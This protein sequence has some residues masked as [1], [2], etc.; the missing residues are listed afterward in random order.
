T[1]SNAILSVYANRDKMSTKGLEVT[2]ARRMDEYWGLNAAYT[3]TFPRATSSDPQ[4]YILTFGRQTFFDPVTGKR[5]VQ[6][7]PRRLTPIDYDRTHQ[8]NLQFNF[9][10]P[11]L[12][13]QGSR[14][15]Q[16][17][18]DI[19]GFATFTFATG[20]PYTAL[21]QSGHPA[22]TNNNDRGPSYK[23]FDLRINKPLPVPGSRF[24][25]ALF[26]EIHNLFNWKNYNIDF[27]NPTT[28]SARV[29]AFT[30]EEAFND[31]PDFRGDRGEKV[32]RISVSD[33][34]DNLPGDDAANLVKIQDI[35]GDGFITKN[36]IVALKLANLLASLDDPRA[37]IRPVEVR[38]GVT[39][40]F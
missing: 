39:V 38:L 14:P 18:R 21:D 2:F 27:I 15:E 33:Q 6:P 36:E 23:N 35:D 24:K 32:N 22:G 10:L 17:L 8:L 12:F 31:R 29:D 11:P 28:G 9:K 25:V 19:H 40:D 26:G 4:E 7:P 34:T 16:V 37:Y 3:L 5:G 13:A 30:L 1:R 20:Q